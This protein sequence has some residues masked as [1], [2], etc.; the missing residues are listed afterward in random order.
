MFIN[1][2]LITG[3][4]CKLSQI[5]FSLGESLLITVKYTMKRGTAKPPLLG[6]NLIHHGIAAAEYSTFTQPVKDLQ[7]HPGD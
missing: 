5:Y 3:S 7:K 6:R 4:W 1:G 2:W